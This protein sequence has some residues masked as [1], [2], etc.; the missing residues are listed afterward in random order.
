MLI[1]TRGSAETTFVEDVFFGLVLDLLHVS[2]R[3]TMACHMF[4]ALAEPLG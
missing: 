3:L 1:R 2:C 4:A